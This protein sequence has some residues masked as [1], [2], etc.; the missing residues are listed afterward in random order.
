[1][2]FSRL[3]HETNARGDTHWSVLFGLLAATTEEDAT[4]WR[5]LWFL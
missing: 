3:R 2:P 1:M 4:R 5:F